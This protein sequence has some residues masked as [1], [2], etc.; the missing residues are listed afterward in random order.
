MPAIRTASRVL[1][2]SVMACALGGCSLFS[3]S[4]RPVPGAQR[5]LYCDIE[6]RP[7][8]TH[9]GPDLLFTAAANPYKWERAYMNPLEGL[10]HTVIG[11][12]RYLSAP[13]E[14]RGAV[15]ESPWQAGHRMPMWFR[16][17]HYLLCRRQALSEVGIAVQTKWG[18]CEQVI[19]SGD[20]RPRCRGWGSR[21]NR[22]LRFMSQA[23]C[24]LEG[25]PKKR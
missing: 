22:G 15:C 13:V 14:I 8:P 20:D 10:V 4:M 12:G 3:S 1:V 25:Q 5:N 16:N 18:A 7:D 19:S 6:Y 9:D 17:S 23:I 11:P 2:A 21:P 24:S